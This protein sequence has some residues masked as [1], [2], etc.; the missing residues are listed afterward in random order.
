MSLC[1]QLLHVKFCFLETLKIIFL[2]AYHTICKINNHYSCKYKY[3]VS[4]IE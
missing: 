4:K 2:S 1:G 3:I